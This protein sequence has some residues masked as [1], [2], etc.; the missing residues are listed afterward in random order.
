MKTPL[1]RYT[2]KNKRIK[3][4]VENRCEGITLNL[5]AG[6][7]MLEGVNEIRNDLDPDA[8]ADYYM[9][10]LQ[11]VE[12]F[13]GNVLFETVLLDPPYSYRKSMEMYGGRKMSAFNAVKNGIDE[14]LTKDGIVIT[15]GYH[16]V[17]MGKTRGFAQEEV[18]LLSHGGAIH[19]TIAIIERKIT[20]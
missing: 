4:W 2:F 20:T 15:F 14:I 10:A 7:N 13:E 19:D 16:S 6:L 11:L 8:P 1:Y 12:Q 18:L 17:S 9:D 3:E 5:F